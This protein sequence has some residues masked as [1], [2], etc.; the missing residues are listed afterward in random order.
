MNYNDQNDFRPQTRNT[1]KD[2]LD[3]ELIE[4]LAN[5]QCTEGEIC[6]ILG[7]SFQSLIT[8]K[9]E[10]I[11]LQEAMTNGYA[12]GKMSLRRAQFQVAFP[13]LDR[14]YNG[15][16]AMLIWLGKQVL[17]QSDKLQVS[18]GDEPVKIQVVWGDLP[19]N[20]KNDETEEIEIKI[21]D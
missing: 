6:S 19:Q 9:K 13:D 21:E 1:K 16:P 5:I 4:R 7:I 20:E 18:G 15:N 2:N 8:W 10:D 3:Y 12:D 17:H 11:K 14:G